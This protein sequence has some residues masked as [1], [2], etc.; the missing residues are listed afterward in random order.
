[1]LVCSASLALLLRLRIQVCTKRYI[2]RLYDLGTIRT[3]DKDKGFPIA[4]ASLHL[5]YLKVEK[6]AKDL[7]IVTA[8]R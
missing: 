8:S 1:M 5:R 2:K 4:K 3:S 6:T 7:V